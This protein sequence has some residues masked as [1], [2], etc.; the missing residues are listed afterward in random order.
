M[1]APFP[2]RRPRG[3]R[4]RYRGLSC[5]RKRLAERASPGRRPRAYAF[6]RLELT[7]PDESALLGVPIGT[8]PWEADP[9]WLCDEAQGRIQRGIKAMADFRLAQQHERRLIGFADMAQHMA[10][11]VTDAEKLRS[12]YAKLRDAVLTSAFERNGASQLIH[13]TVGDHA[14]GTPA[15]D[16]GVAADLAAAIVSAADLRDVVTVYGNTIEIGVDDKTPASTLV[17]LLAGIY[18]PAAA[19]RG[20]LLRNGYGWPAHFDPET[21]SA[22]AD[23][24]SGPAKEVVAAPPSKSSPKTRGPAPGT[25]DRYAA[26]DRALYPE[27]AGLIATGL[28]MTAATED[29]ADADKIAGTGTKASRAKRLARRFRQEQEQDRDARELGP[30]RSRTISN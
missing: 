12:A 19:A 5:A 28:S 4:W 11:G 6:R 2:R 24:D 26:S 14:L 8:R 13:L 20:W 1:L 10:G 16:L 17:E 27:I 30:T 29:L 25:V 3:P 9:D 7:V 15:V 22:L 23:T 18:L 21:P